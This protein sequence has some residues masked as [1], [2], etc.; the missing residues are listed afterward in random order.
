MKNQALSLV[1]I[2][3]G[4]LSLGAAGC[5]LG[6]DP[7]H[8][9][10][11][12]NG[13]AGATTGTA[14]TSGGAGGG[15]GSGPSLD[16]IAGNALATFDTTTESF[17]FSTYSEGPN[18]ASLPGTTATIDFDADDGSP[19]GGSLKVYAP[20][21]GANQYVDI[22]SKSFSPNLQNWKGGKL[23]VRV[24]VD[25]GSTFSGQ[26]E[27][28]ADTGAGFTFVGTSIN[29]MAGGG[30]HD[31][32]VTL[33]T[34]MTR[35]SGYDLTQVIVYGVHI[36]S[37]TG[38][39]SQGPVTFHIDSFSLEGVAVDAGTDTAAPADTGT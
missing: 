5:I 39:A 11:L 12:Y 17:A 19:S 16:T 13:G 7:D 1:S 20:Y 21:T 32:V 37:G 24:K 23:H 33:D 18:I 8:N 36:G 25:A 10:M 38:G 34:A 29:V 22:Q 35:N 28:Y 14:G 27:P 6:S 3:V 30:W 9:S 26:I 4:G 2:I 31:Y 15:G